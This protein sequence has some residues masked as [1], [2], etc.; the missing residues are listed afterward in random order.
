M[1]AF[2]KKYPFFNQPNVVMNKVTYDPVNRRDAFILVDAVTGEPYRGDV[3]SEDTIL[4]LLEKKNPTDPYTRRPI[5]QKMGTEGA[6]IPK[7]APK[8][9]REL[10]N[11]RKPT[12]EKTRVMG[13]KTTRVPKPIPVKIKKSIKVTMYKAEG[14]GSWRNGCRL[15]ND[16]F[17]TPWPKVKKIVMAMVAWEL[18]RRIRNRASGFYLFSRETRQSLCEDLVRLVNIDLVKKKMIIPAFDEKG[19][20]TARFTR[21][22]F[23][24]GNKS[25]MVRSPSMMKSATLRSVERALQSPRSKTVGSP[26]PIPSPNLNDV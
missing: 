17:V 13:K 22:M 2:L 14:R 11:A 1:E 18:D 3:Y 10:L 7:R 12:S 9:L 23:D 6:V 21:N 15:N 24:V 5:V 26:L 25:R 19:V 16:R 4:K 20:F 8:G